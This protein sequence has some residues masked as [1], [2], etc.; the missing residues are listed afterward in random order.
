MSAFK[1]VGKGDL[2]CVQ[3][4][5]SPGVLGGIAQVLPLD[6]H[7]AWSWGSAGLNFESILCDSA[8]LRSETPVPQLQRQLQPQCHL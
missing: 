6:G 1:A 2:L 3:K 4:S 8:Q 7:M 5:E